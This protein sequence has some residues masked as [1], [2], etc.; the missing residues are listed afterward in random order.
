MTRAATHYGTCQ[1]CGRQHM[2]PAGVLA[3][4]GYV[5]K[6]RGQGGYFA[7][8]CNGAGYLPYQQAHDALD[9]EIERATAY[10]AA[11]P[12]EIARLAACTDTTISLTFRNSNV[13]DSREW[14]VTGEVVLTGAEFY[15]DRFGLK[16]AAGKVWKIRNNE[17]R[18]TTVEHFVRHHWDGRA[19]NCRRELAAMTD[20][21]AHQ[22]QRRADWK[23]D[24]PLT[25]RHR[26]SERQGAA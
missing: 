2:L 5:V 25:P 22:R 19:E 7:G 4:H 6:H 23:P 11:I 21:I 12:A 18:L 20:Y 16:D 10:A 8:V 1:V 3:K 26:R 24:Q 14:P 15:M 9:A 17:H 13:W